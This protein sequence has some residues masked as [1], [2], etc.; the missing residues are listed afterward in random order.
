[1]AAVFEQFS[2]RPQRF[3]SNQI[4]NP[5]MT[6]R[7]FHPRELELIDHTLLNIARDPIPLTQYGLAAGRSSNPS[8]LPPISGPS[9]C[10]SPWFGKAKLPSGESGLAK[11][12]L[13]D[14]SRMKTVT[15]QPHL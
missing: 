12:G 5:T 3:N 15:V 8:Q 1:M 13:A 9:P 2:P 4:V 14:A 7:D 10:Y 11:A 6:K